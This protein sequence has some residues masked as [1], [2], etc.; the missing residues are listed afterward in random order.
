MLDWWKLDFKVKNVD[1]VASFYM[2]LKPDILVS[3][4]AKNRLFTLTEKMMPDASQHD[5]KGAIV[6]Q[7]S[8]NLADITTYLKGLKSWQG[9][10]VPPARACGE[11]I[12]EIVRHGST[13]PMHLIYQLEIP[14]T[15]G[16]IKTLKMHKFHSHQY[17]KL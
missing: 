14:T 7:V 17:D 15:L 2:L 13:G 10:D 12:Y 8:E 3:P 5:L 11:G 6:T 4:T 16:E 1:E 9:L